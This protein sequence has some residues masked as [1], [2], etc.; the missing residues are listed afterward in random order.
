MFGCLATLKRA[1]SSA[2][3]FVIHLP[4]M[5]CFHLRVAEVTQNLHVVE[6]QEDLSLVAFFK[7][8]LLTSLAPCLQVIGV[9]AVFN[10]SHSSSKRAKHVA[11]DNG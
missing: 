8:Q 9:G 4:A 1:W 2:G 6:F 11:T 5:V 7:E 10:E 3:S